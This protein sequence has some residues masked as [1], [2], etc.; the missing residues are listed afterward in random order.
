[1]S[2]ANDN[3][4]PLPVVFSLEEGVKLLADVINIATQVTNWKVGS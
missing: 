4:K 1:M 2:P 3:L